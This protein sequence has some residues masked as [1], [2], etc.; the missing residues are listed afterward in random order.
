MSAVKIC[1][2]F[3]KTRACDGRVLLLPVLD[4]AAENGADFLLIF[5]PTDEDK[6]AKK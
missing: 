2:L 3:K 6:K 1:R 5:K 4:P